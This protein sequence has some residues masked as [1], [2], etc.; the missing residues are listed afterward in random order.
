[1]YDSPKYN[2]RNAPTGGRI[3]MA[4]IGTMYRTTVSRHVS[5]SPDAR[6]TVMRYVMR[7]PS[8]WPVRIVGTM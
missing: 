7:L 5:R 2:A 1:M 3:G 4:A 6:S 8:V